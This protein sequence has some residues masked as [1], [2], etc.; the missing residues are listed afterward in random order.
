VIIPVAALLVVLAP[1]A[2]GGRLGLLGEIRL[3]RV[4]VAAAAFVVQL[5][6]IEVIPGPSWLL[7][8]L[9]LASYLGAAWFVQANRRVPGLVLLGVGALSN[10]VTIA[11]NGGTL[12]ASPAALR[13]AGFSD[14]GSGFVNSGVVPD[15]VLPW[16]GDVFAVPASWPLANVFSVGDVLIVLGAG[17][18]SWRI[19]GTRWT[20][21][22][23]PRPAR[24][25][26]GRHIG[27]RAP[28]PTPGRTPVPG[29]RRWF[30]T[31]AHSGHT[32]DVQSSA[33]PG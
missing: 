8:G 10:G 16:L 21:T 24:H 5:V 4:D 29:G 17:Y 11:L 22:W 20:P 1:L 18:A 14:A 26:R 19:C 9:H 27:G 13:A 12:P 28:R 6:A 30:V 31:T 7:R 25:A 32:A 33:S 2:L 15:P 3:R 23:D